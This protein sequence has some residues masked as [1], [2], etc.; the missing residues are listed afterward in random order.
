MKTLQMVKKVNTIWKKGEA[1]QTNNNVCKRIILSEQRHINK[2]ILTQCY[3]ISNLNHET[4]DQFDEQF[5]HFQFF[6]DGTLLS[7]SSAHPWVL[8]PREIIHNGLKK[9]SKHV[10][11]TF[12]TKNICKGRKN[13]EQWIKLNY[14]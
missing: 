6:L 10:S 2:N 3:R 8:S 5:L 12:E 13:V 14:Y 1:I 9:T 7:D 4:I 11:S